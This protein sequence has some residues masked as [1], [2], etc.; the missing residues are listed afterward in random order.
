LFDLEKGGGKF[1]M[2]G[3]DSSFYQGNLSYSPIITDVTLN[4]FG[5]WAFKMDGIF[6]DGLDVNLCTLSCL[7]MADTGRLHFLYISTFH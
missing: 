3:S 5:Y 6:I 1:I 2:G 7:A 4:P